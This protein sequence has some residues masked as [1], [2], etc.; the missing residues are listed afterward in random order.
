MIY[1][2]FYKSKFLTYVIFLMPKEL[3]STFLAGQI[4]WQ[5]AVS[6]IVCLRKVL[7]LFHI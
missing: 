2:S 4:C 3:L 6:V 7:F 1:L 5:L